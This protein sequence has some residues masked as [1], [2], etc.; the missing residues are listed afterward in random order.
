MG[1]RWAEEMHAYH[2]IRE[3]FRQKLRHP[4]RAAWFENKRFHW[5]WPKPIVLLANHNPELGCVICTVLHF[6]TARPWAG[7]GSCFTLGLFF[8]LS[9]TRP[10]PP[11]CRISNDV[12]CDVYSPKSVE[13]L[14]HGQLMLR[15]LFS[16]VC[17]KYIFFW[18]YRSVGFE[19]NNKYAKNAKKGYYSR[20]SIIRTSIIRTFFLVPFFSWILISF[21]LKSFER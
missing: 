12:T 11:L 18:F 13:K 9:V 3:N 16:L 2:K 15:M 6:L 19:E 4:G 21:D 10:R 20:T 8:V 1:D 7:R 5:S 14:I 17:V